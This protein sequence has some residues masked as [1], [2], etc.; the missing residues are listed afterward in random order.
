MMLASLPLV[1]GGG[2][3]RRGRSVVFLV[4]LGTVAD[5][6]VVMQPVFQQFSEF[7][8]PQFQFLVRVLDIPV[9]PQR[10][11]HCA[12]L[13]LVV[14]RPLLRNGRCHGGRRSCAFCISA[15][16]GTTVGTCTA[17]VTEAFWTISPL[18]CVEVDSDPAVCRVSCLCHCATDR[19][20]RTLSVRSCRPRRR[21]QWYAWFCW[22]RC[23]SREAGLLVL[24][25]LR[26][27][28]LSCMD[29]GLLL[30][31]LL[32]EGSL[33]CGVREVALR[34]SMF[35]PPVRVGESTCF[36]ESHNCSH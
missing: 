18:L 12:V 15:M 16:P 2:R 30:L 25:L 20:P 7:L 33:S 34:I 5:V 13:G 26:E 27:C 28:S 35:L 31:P 21:Q 17:S 8:V 6:P 22:L 4:F 1:P 23:T 10:R 19:C 3:G 32:R 36:I 29:A 11:I 24:P 9:M 14:T